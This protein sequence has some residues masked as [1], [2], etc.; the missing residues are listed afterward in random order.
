M[1]EATKQIIV[2]KDERPHL[3]TTNITGT[4]TLVTKE[5]LIAKKLLLENIIKNIN[6]DI[7]LFK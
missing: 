4:N 5:E 3:M 7:A 6:D 2:D 1:A